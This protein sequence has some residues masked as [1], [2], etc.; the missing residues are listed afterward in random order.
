MTKKIRCAIYTRKS[1]EDGLEQEFNS[2]HAQR[3][4]CAAYITSQK[5]EGWVLLPE[6][7]DDGGI[8]GATLD[9]PSLQCLLSELD[10]G[11]VDQIV[12]YKIDRLSRSLSDFARIVDRLDGAGASFVSITQSF[13][14]ATS[15]GRLTLNMLLSF[16]Q[17][18]REVT[19]ER[20]RDKIA[21]SKRK[22]LWMGGNVPL[23][24][25]PN[26]R[27]L[28]INESEAE[29][30]R[31]IYRMY[32][33]HKTTFEV[34]TEAKR[35]G[36]R[37]KRRTT[38]SGEIKGGNLIDRGHI[39]H[40]L[41]NPIYAGRIRHKKAVFEGQHP[42]IIDP[43]DWDEIQRKLSN[44]SGRKRG[45]RVA[46]H[47]S[48]LAGKLFDETGD[49]LTPS[50]SS[51]DGKRLRYYISRRLATGKSREHPDAWRLPAPQLE[52]SIARVVHSHLA[53]PAI[54]PKLLGKIDATKLDLLQAKTNLLA[55]TV[56]P[57][58]TTSKWSALIYLATIAPGKLVVE[59]NGEAISHQLDVPEDHIE[60]NHLRLNAA[61]QLR[62]KG[63]ET[64]IILGCEPPEVDEVLVRNIVKS[65]NWFEAIKR[66]ETFA[67]IAA[68]EGTSKRRI[69]DVVD[70]AFL[71]PDILADV[72]AGTLPMNVTS[73]VLIKQGIPGRWSEQRLL[74]KEN[75]IRSNAA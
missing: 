73:D 20:I 27:T 56:A 29:T 69:Q 24:Y 74:F 35:K 46:A 36:L 44:R 39:Y 28:T 72:V 50:H 26:G 16:A 30:V 3:E 21:A 40:I 52:Q 12:V 31:A 64:K 25:D 2:L 62:R 22:G 10:E 14:T 43:Q 48:P 55:D 68:R 1:S 23:G 75:P 42:A 61:F 5:A 71:A 4:A 45:V 17:F 32:H 8:S 53:D 66:G 34:T 47:P 15:M 38:P 57:H 7:Y 33:T 60:A 63:V 51:K 37:S 58:Q 19:A 67:T 13:N 41:T 54:L 9:R 65:R 59:L 6:L 70:L 11:R 18:E 49:R